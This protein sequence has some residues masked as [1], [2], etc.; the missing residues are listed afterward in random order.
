MLCGEMDTSEEKCQRAACCQPVRQSP[1]GHSVSQYS[2]L[3]EWMSFYSG[4]AYNLRP[5]RISS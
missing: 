5:L 2:R 3:T 4:L 1:I